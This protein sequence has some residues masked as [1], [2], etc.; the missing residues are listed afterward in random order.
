MKINIYSVAEK[1]PPIGETI[2]RWYLEE[3]GDV[4]FTRFDRAVECR[5]TDPEEIALC[6]ETGESPDFSWEEHGG[7]YKT[8]LWS[9]CCV[10]KGE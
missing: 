3:N 8:D 6:L 4:D 5:T 9:F 7:M 2:I 10:S 1:H